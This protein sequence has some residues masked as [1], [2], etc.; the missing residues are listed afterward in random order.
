MMGVSERDS[1]ALLLEGAG[2]VFSVC[3]SSFLKIRELEGEVKSSC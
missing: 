2:A 1:T 3:A